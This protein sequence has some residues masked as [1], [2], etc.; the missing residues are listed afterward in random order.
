MVDVKK[1]VCLPLP[2]SFI[3]C[4]GHGPCSL[5]DDCARHLTIRCDVFDGSCTVQERVCTPEERDF[6][7]PFTDPE[8][9]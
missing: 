3:R 6:Y 1:R 9:A 2:T 8:P 5:A 7:L 4:L